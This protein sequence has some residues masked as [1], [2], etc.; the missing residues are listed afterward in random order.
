[1]NPAKQILLSA[2]WTSRTLSAGS[3]RAELES[4]PESNVNY[5]PSIRVVVGAFPDLSL[6]RDPG[7]IPTYFHYDM[8]GFQN[9][10]YR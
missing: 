10:M 5:V 3:C 6:P 4:S 2:N 7:L 9:G 8:K 1:M